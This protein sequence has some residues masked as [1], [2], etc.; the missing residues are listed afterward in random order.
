MELMFVWCEHRCAFPTANPTRHHDL[1]QLHLEAIFAHTLRSPFDGLLEGL[2][3]AQAMADSVAKLGH[4]LIGTA[5]RQRGANETLGRIAIGLGERDL[6]GAQGRGKPEAQ[7]QQSRN[8][9][10]A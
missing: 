5:A 9:D 7:T 8:A 1:L 2:G 10:G 3:T 6:A 4:A